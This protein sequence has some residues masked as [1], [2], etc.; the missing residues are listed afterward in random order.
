MPHA[1]I[2]GMTTS[3][4]S[5]LAK[6][7]CEEFN[8]AGVPTLAL[9]KP[10]E[11]Y[12]A[13]WQTTDADAFL[14][15]F[16]ASRGCA[17]FMEMSDVGIDKFDT[18]FHE[19]FSKGR[20]HGHRVFYVSQRHTQVHPC[21]RENCENL[22]LFRVSQKSAAIWAEEFADDGILAATSAPRYHFV[23]CGRYTPARLMP[24]I[25]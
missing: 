2:I 21:I 19:P 18:R 10:G 17:A 6:K 24:P 20:H 14:A 4:K 11:P 16:W 5:T 13:Q 12:P 8:R 7:L 25:A 22:Y 9:C 1:A 3:G 23:M 15:K